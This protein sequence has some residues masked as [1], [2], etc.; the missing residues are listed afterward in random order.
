[1]IVVAVLALTQGSSSELMAHHDGTELWG[2]NYAHKCDTTVYS[3]CVANDINH[4]YGFVDLSTARQA[5][6]Q[7]ALSNLYG[8]NSEINVFST[9][10]TDLRVI[11]TYSLVDIFAWTQCAAGAVTH[12]SDINHEGY[13]Q[14][15][16]FVWQ[17][18]ANAANKVNTTAKYNY[19]GCHEVGHSVGLR[20]RD[21]STCMK[22]VVCVPSNASCVVLSTQNPLASDYARINN[23]YPIQ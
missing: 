3:Q 1:V 12:G 4:F 10:S 17:T 13:C 5:A 6:S 20:H 2:S 21:A 23:H 16:Q 15:Q 22:P 9:S 11:E 19:I 18:H 7:R 14:P 8:A